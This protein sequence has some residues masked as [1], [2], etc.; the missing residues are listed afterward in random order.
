PYLDGDDTR[1]RG[2]GVSSDQVPVLDRHWDAGGKLNPDP[3]IGAAGWCG[4]AARGVLAA[5]GAV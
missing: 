4:T 2:A 5:R 3:P 1:R